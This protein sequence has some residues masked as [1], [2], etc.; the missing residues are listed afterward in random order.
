MSIEKQYSN[1][2]EFEAD[3]LITRFD[4]TYD[5]VLKRYLKDVRAVEEEL[6]F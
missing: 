3:L 5:P 2:S 6:E 4:P 1:P